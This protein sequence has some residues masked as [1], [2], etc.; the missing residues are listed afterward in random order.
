M[1]ISERREKEKKEM[2]GLI[3]ETAMKLFLEE[4][5]DNVSLRRIADKIEYSPATI[6]LYFKDKDEI[7]FALH[8]EGFEKLYA[9]QQTTL[10][11]KDPL[12]RLWKQGEL[13]IKFGLENP[14]YYNL[15]FIMRS[16]AKKICVEQKWDTGL[17][18]YSFLQENVAECMQ[19]GLLPKTDV[20]VATFSFWSHVHGIVSLIIRER[21]IMIPEQHLPA[22]VKG[23]LDFMMEVFTRK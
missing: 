11:I 20:A 10:D 8:E 7:L 16:P 6:Y 23:A 14:E 21:C 18:S 4:G 15:M 19:A 1:G 13:Y 9:L 5:V 2:R 12:K 17:R 3:L 22:F